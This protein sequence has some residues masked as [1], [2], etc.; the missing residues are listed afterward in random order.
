MHFIYMS[1]FLPKAYFRIY[2]HTANVQ[3]PHGG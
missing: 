2:I 3:Q 1:L